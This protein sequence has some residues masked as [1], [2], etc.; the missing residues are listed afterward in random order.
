MEIAVITGA[1][2][3]LGVEF[4]KETASMYPELDEIWLIARRMDRLTELADKYGS[5]KCVPVCLDLS[6]DESYN[7]LDRLLAD[8]NASVRLLVNNAGFGKL[9]FVKD[10]RI[11]IQ[12]AMIDLNCKG[13]TGVACACL[14]HMVR[15]AQIINTCSIASFAPNTRLTVYSSTK[16]YVKSFTRGL[17]T[18]LKPYGI[19]CM[20]VCPGP[21]KTEFI[22]I[23]AIQP[24][25]SKTFDI[26]PYC[27]VNKVARGA[28]R[29]SKKGVCVYTP[30]AFYKV[31]R[32]LAK[33]LPHSIVVKICGA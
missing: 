17:H 30:S 12:T 11:P 23:A 3:G 13:L 33:L 24:G 18:E 1:S 26:L 22:E 9:G 20:C 28:L 32:V 15:G 7:D 8:K 21:M 2:S 4:I 25:T 5:G 6:E 16:A 27:D 14:K 29:A 19:G 10:E 31:Y